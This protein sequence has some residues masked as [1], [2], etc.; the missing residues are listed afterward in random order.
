MSE[1]ATSIASEPLPDDMNEQ[2]SK[3]LSYWQ[4]KCET[5]TY[6]PFP[7]L[8]ELDIMDLFEMVGNLIICEVV[9]PKQGQDDKPIRYRW[10]YWGSDLSAFFGVELNGKFIDESYTPTTAQQISSCYDWMLETK[11][12]HY[13]KRQGGS[14]TSDGNHLT[15]ENESPYKGF[16]R[17]ACPVIDKTGEISHLFGIITFTEASTS[18]T[19]EWDDN[20][21]GEIFQPD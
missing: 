12:I 13:W 7:T 14:V 18:N 3:V 21:I 20:A 5:T 17:L 16:E 11:E 9:R 15:I 1:P 19:T 8:T 4:G 6:G 2:M 10:L